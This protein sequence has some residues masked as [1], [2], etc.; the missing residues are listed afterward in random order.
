[1]GGWG[2]HINRVHGLLVILAILASGTLYAFKGSAISAQW[3]SWIRGACLAAV[4]VFGI[5]TLTL[6]LPGALFVEVV[7]GSRLPADSAWPLAIGIT[8]LGALTIVPACLALRFLVPHARGW[9]HAGLTAVLSVVASFLF[10][11][12]IVPAQPR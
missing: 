6:G 10:T 5:G 8:Q 7:A 4:M 2:G 3:W 11:I 1:M 12:I 9:Q